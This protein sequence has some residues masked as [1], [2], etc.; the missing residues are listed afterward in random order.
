MKPAGVMGLFLRTWRTEWVGMTRGQLAL[1]L[2]ARQGVRVTD[3]VVRA[4][5]TGQPPATTAE[6]DAL[7]DVMSRHGLTR[8]EIDDFRRAILAA[9]CDRQYSDLFPDE[10]F[11]Y[12]DDVDDYPSDLTSLPSFGPEIEDTTEIWSWDASRILTS[13]AQITVD[14]TGWEIQPR[15]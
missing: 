13:G 11:A 12:Q 3:S 4:W 14:V 7:L 10:D 8:P 6:F 15:N 5:E 9:V 2:S 1:A